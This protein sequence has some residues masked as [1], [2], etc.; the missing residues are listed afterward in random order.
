MGERMMIRKIKRL[1]DRGS[2]TSLR[3]VAELF[4]G[5][6]NKRRQHEEKKKK[7]EKPRSPPEE[8]KKKR[9]NPR[10][11]SAAAVSEA[12]KEKKKR[13]KPRSPPAT[14]VSEASKEIMYLKGVHASRLDRHVV[15]C[16]YFSKVIRLDSVY[17]N[18]R[19]Y[20]G[21]SLSS[22]QL[23][24]LAIVDFDV[25]LDLNPDD[26]ASLFNRAEAYSKLYVSF[27]DAEGGG[28]A[29]RQASIRDL[30]EYLAKEP[31]DN[32]AH[33]LLDML[34]ADDKKKKTRQNPSKKRTRDAA[35]S[36]S[37]FTPTPSKPFANM[38]IE[39]DRNDEGRKEI[40]V[41]CS[42]GSIMCTP[43]P[44][45]DTKSSASS[46]RKS[47][48]GGA[49][50]R[51]RRRGSDTKKSFDDTFLRDNQS[52]R[53]P[54][55]IRRA[56]S[57]A[58]TSEKTPR[59]V[60]KKRGIPSSMKKRKKS[61]RKCVNFDKILIREHARELGGSGGVPE[62]GG[63]ALG[64]TDEHEDKSPVP[65]DK[66]EMSRSPYRAYKDDYRPSPAKERRKLLQEFMGP[67]SYRERH[68][69]EVRELAR[70]RKSRADATENDRRYHP[71][72]DT[73]EMVIDE[74]ALGSEDALHEIR[75]RLGL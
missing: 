30:T 1:L 10:S 68:R 58:A 17:E 49:S 52:S 51:R 41:E 60:L 48:R 62:C 50:Q 73:L 5:Y 36:S 53:T 72:F 55:P 47:G 12:S 26:T 32:E 63:I 43:S 39:E 67:E 3:Q 15:A 6:D 22:L 16:E 59:S 45:A 19:A 70:L 65:I 37:T 11:P 21:M 9:E 33:V 25:A 13:E 31:E 27:H 42:L 24:T 29:A 14:A 18:A 75:E 64:L 74:S 61:A 56:G 40:D 35:D 7:R 8:K 69:E 66:Y 4:D 34:T 23:W 28:R 38:S 57:A 46:R 71:D 20:R 2:E 44:S 54:S